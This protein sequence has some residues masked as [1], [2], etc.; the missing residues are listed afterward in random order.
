M[1]AAAPLALRQLFSFTFHAT[2][3]FMT[4]VWPTICPARPCADA[5]EALTILV[6]AATRAELSPRRTDRGHAVWTIADPAMR[7]ITKPGEHRGRRVAVVVTVLAG[8][9]DVAAEEEAEL[10][11]L[12]A[13]RRLAAVPALGTPEPTSPPPA[14]GTVIG[15]KSYRAWVALETQRLALERER[16]RKL[17]LAVIDNTRPPRG[18]TPAVAQMVALRERTERAR[19]HAEQQRIASHERTARH[20]ITQARD[21]LFLELVARLAEVDAA[22]SAELIAR[23]RERLAKWEAQGKI[24]RGETT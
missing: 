3:R 4:R 14:V 6:D 10:E 18:M 22:G 24:A 21:E 9:D 1:T 13:S 5:R 15:E 16:L 12:E 7:W 17:Q 23:A 11:V 8:G 2:Q 20:L 19:L